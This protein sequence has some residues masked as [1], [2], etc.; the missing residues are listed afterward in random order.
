MRIAAGVLL[1]IASLFNGCA[2]FK[3]GIQGGATAA[4]DQAAGGVSNA[5]VEGGG[6]GLSAEQAEE[7]KKQ[8]KDSLG[9][10]NA[11]AGL[12]T[13]GIFLLVM[14]GLQI[15]GAVMLFIAKS[16]MLVLVI[17]VLG[18]AAEVIGPA[19]YNAGFGMVNIFGLIASLLAIIASRTYS[20]K[21]AAA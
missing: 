13:L 5:V 17:G 14:F 16:A 3:Y 19:V 12:A 4:A 21:A 9:P 1:I 18:I 6:Q 8:L 7:M 11:A 2:G 20:G 15:A 10:D